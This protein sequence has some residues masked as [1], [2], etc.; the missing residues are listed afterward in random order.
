MTIEFTGRR[1]I[2]AASR[3]AFEAKVGGKEVWCSVSMDAL[4]DHFGNTGTSSHELIQSFEANRP[5][6]EAAAQRVLER[7]G[8]QSV[9]LETRDLD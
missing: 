4:N 9:E 2:V 5:R 7:N 8:G 1:H 3:V 6:I